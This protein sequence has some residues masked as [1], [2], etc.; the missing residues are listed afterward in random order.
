MLEMLLL[1]LI[2]G[3]VILA[4][5]DK[6]TSWLNDLVQKLN[7][8]WQQI[9]VSVPHAARVFGDLIMGAIA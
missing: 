7:A 5:W 1:G 6:I 4:N 3:A 2:G 8:V 9:R